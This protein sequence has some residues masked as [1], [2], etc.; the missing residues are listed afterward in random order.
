MQAGILPVVASNVSVSMRRRSAAA[1]TPAS[2]ASPW[3]W[4]KFATGQTIQTGVSEWT[5]AWG[6]SSRKLTQANTARQPSLEVDNTILF[7]N[8]SGASA[9]ALGTGAVSI[10][11]PWSVILYAKQV[12]WTSTRRL[13]G[14][15]NGTVFQHSATPTLA[16]ITGS[17]VAANSDLALNTYAMIT[18]VFNGASS[19]LAINTNT[20]ATGDAGSS[21]STA[22]ILG[23]TGGSAGMQVWECIVTNAALSAG[24][25]ASAYA[26]GQAQGFVA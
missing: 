4:Y 14:A 3:A 6:N 20:P 16:L 18:A 12:S 9:N 5:D 7:A 2:L 23:S 11:Q 1:W 25:I 26:Y 21:A 8:A 24:D 22:F 19:Q 17:P 13:I 15:V 10:S